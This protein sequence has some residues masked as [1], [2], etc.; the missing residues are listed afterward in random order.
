MQIVQEHSIDESAFD[1][2]HPYYDPKS[3]D[4]NK[5]KWELVHVKFMHKFVDLI[6][7]KELKAHM[8]PGEPLQHL[9]TLKQ[10]RLSVSSVSPKEWNFIMV[11][12]SSCPYTY[13]ASAQRA[14]NADT[15]TVHLLKHLLPQD[16]SGEEFDEDQP[17]QHVEEGTPV[18]DETDT[19][20]AHVNGDGKADAENE[21]GACD[22]DTDV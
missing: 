6:T 11:S 22:S 14:A 12:L 16:L 18:D 19:L 4:R 21:T 7:L 3:T 2:N 1:P 8:G 20:T 13:R 15:N 10:S 9:Q 17:L 5:P